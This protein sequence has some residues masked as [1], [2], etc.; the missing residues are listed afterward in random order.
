MSVGCV[1]S[2]AGCG[3]KGSD[4]STA[5]TAD[6]PGSPTGAATD[7]A[8]RIPIRGS[9]PSKTSFFQL[10]PEST[11]ATTVKEQ[12]TERLATFLREPG[13]WLDG[14]WA[15][16][17]VHPTWIDHIERS[18]TEIT[19]AIRDDASWS[20]GTPITGADVAVPVIDF[21]I[22]RRFRP[23]Y[24]SERKDQPVVILGAF[25]GIDIGE[26]SV[27]YRSS[28]GYFDGFWDFAIG[29]WL[30]GDVVPT[31]AEPYD[32]YAAD[33]IRT[34]HRAQRGEIDPWSRDPW[35]D[36]SAPTRDSLRAKHLA[37]R[38]YVY[39]FSD[40]ENVLATGAWDLVALRG[41]EAFVFR[42]NVHHRNADADADADAVAVDVERM[43][44]EYTP[45]TRRERAG[46]SADRLDYGS[47]VT[48]P[49][50][51]E[52]FPDS[53]R[54]LL[55]PGGYLSGNGLELNFD[56]PALGQRPVRAAIMYALDQEAI[57][58][59]VHPTA[60]NP[61]ETP[62]GDCWDATDYVS[63][64]WIDENLTTYATD[65]ERAA[66]LLRAAGFAR[67]D[68][69]WRD[70][71]GVALELTIATDTETPRWEPAV[72][73]Q[74]REFGVPTTVTSLGGDQFSDRVDRGAFPAWA[75]GG[76]AT[77]TAPATLVNWYQ[78]ARKPRKYGI[79][80]DEQFETGRFSRQGEPRPLTT[81][82]Y[83]VF[84]VEAPPIG[85]PEASL[86][87]YHPAS[88]AL[89]FFSNPPP[90]VFRE[91]VRLGLWLANWYLPTIPINKTLEQHFID[92]AHWRWPTGSASWA[93][94]TAGG[95]RT[96]PGIL[97]SGTVRAARKDGSQG[98]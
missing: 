35:Q 71:S 39:K 77:S 70:E 92:E 33:V 34:V 80:P 36:E 98:G 3:G 1:A 87:E 18:P 54:Q 11:F 23:V 90:D 24:A 81:E 44:L 63:R 8:L 2:L 30:V 67:T 65:R 37:E 86:R 73:S 16:G 61:V 84:T 79:Y 53:I 6:E 96:M 46:L 26:R 68:G 31:H 9:D 42:P 94:F 57:A 15:G 76:A 27:T 21:T 91:R 48:P 52:S 28:Q 62:G 74:L 41:S 93:N 60:A 85:R 38:Q 20:D 45:S 32:G 64:E 50:V 12:P 97:A 56:H 43:L 7:R 69:S 47:G 25:D 4:G 19:I 95:P 59:T 78:A 72:A 75:A 22:S 51:V 89:V 10:A 17:D 58:E 29:H 55:V 14:L 5:T 82:R 88:A 83:D 66:M 13:V 40:P 49:S